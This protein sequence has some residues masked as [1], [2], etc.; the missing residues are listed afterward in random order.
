MLIKMSVPHW[1][2]PLM[3]QCHFMNTMVHST[4][5]DFHDIFLCS[6]MKVYQY[7]HIHHHYVMLDVLLEYDLTPAF[8]TLTVMY[9]LK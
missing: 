2:E 5:A 7:M 3:Q 4:T 6:T 1:L 9:T 8:S